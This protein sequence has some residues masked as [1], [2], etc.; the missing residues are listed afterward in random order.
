[1]L[2]LQWAADS[3]SA[4]HALARES[5]RQEPEGSSLSRGDAAC[6]Q[7]SV[8]LGHHTLSCVLVSFPT[9]AG[10]EAASFDEVGQA[11]FIGPKA[12]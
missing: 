9:G 8:G 2:W 1:M 10:L 11:S 6:V 7:V 4:W 3:P 12:R 5:F